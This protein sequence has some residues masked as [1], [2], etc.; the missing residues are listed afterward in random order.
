MNRSLL[1]ALAVLLLL[2]PASSHA[3]SAPAAPVVVEPTP[4]S[5]VDD[6]GMWIDDDLLAFGLDEDFVFDTVDF[7]GL[8][9]GGMQVEIGRAHV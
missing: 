4:A 8:D 7:D 2:S 6:E 3:Q 1:A 5:P 9:A